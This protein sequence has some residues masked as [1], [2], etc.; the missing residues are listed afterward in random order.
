VQAHHLSRPATHLALGGTMTD[1]AEDFISPHADNPWILDA[2]TDWIAETKGKAGE[3][4]AGINLFVWAKENPDSAFA[5]IQTILEL[6][7]DDEWLFT[8]AAAGPLETFLTRCPDHFVEIVFKV[9]SIDA[10]LRR[11][12]Q[13]V[14]QCGMSNDRYERIRQL[15]ESS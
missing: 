15:A 8:Q 10:R 14:W 11:A 12:F 13:H 2:A 9:A 7:N 4:T 1:Q 5:V 6:T 3:H